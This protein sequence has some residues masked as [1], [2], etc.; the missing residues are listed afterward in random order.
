MMKL[1][2]IYRNFYLVQMGP[3]M[4]VVAISTLAFHLVTLVNKLENIYY[5][6]IFILYYYYH[7]NYCIC[8]VLFYYYFSL[9]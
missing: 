9:V 7:V 5:F 6:I 2:C 3:P 4:S 8:T 1:D